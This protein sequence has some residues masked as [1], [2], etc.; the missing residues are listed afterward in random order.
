MR[1]DKHAKLC[2]ASN[3]REHIRLAL[4]GGTTKRPK[5]PA[6]LL[7]RFGALAYSRNPSE[8]NFIIISFFFIDRTVS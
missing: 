3:N 8:I 5:T 1:A 6:Y 4:V 7:K 2:G